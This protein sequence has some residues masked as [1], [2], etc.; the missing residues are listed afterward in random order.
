[1]FT[2]QEGARVINIL[3]TASADRWDT[4][5][6]PLL[7]Y[8]AQ[9]ELTVDLRTSFPPEDV[10]YIIYAPDSLLKDFSPFTRLKA[11]LNLWAG[12]EGVVHNDTLKVPLTKMVENGLTESMVE[13]VSAHVLRYHLD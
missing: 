11:V 2:D 3:F 9:S 13:W 6:A 8:F 7:K 12:V 10:D 1:M 4:Y 5:E